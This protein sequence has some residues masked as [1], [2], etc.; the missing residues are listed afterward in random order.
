M[1]AS[2]LEK[3]FLRGDLSTTFLMAEVKSPIILIRRD[4][5]PEV[6][7]LHND[8]S[9]LNEQFILIIPQNKLRNIIIF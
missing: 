9:T 2:K 3:L 4:F 8:Y 5:L 7:T 1:Q 6:V